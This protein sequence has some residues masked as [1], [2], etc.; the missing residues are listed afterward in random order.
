MTHLF[1]WT[2]V[3]NSEFQWLLPNRQTNMTLLSKSHI[4]YLAQN[5]ENKQKKKI[6]GSHVPHL[7]WTDMKIRIILKYVP[8]GLITGMF[9]CS[10]LR[11]F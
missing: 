4:S 6:K 10:K 8:T 9:S 2:F 11:V 1:S 7:A 3:K 5:M